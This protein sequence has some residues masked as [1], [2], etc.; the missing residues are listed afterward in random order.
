MKNSAFCL[1]S[2]K[3][4]ILYTSFNVVF[5]IHYLNTKIHS[6][7]G[8][9]HNQ[10]IHSFNILNSPITNNRRKL[11]VQLAFLN[12]LFFNNLVLT[13]G[14]KGFQYCTPVKMKLNYQPNITHCFT[15]ISIINY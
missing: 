12:Q 2:N 1:Y 14:K 13:G 3:S 7:S 15:V 8:F 10:V 4:D 9:I 11:R 5:I 6:L